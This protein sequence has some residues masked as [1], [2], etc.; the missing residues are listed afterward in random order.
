[1]AL[2]T[3]LGRHLS[4]LPPRLLQNLS[5]KSACPLTLIKVGT[6]D[7]TFRQ[8]RCECHYTSKL[9]QLIPVPKLA[10]GGLKESHSM[11]DP[12]Y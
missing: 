2:P 5:P 8:R 3:T 12:A 11:L 7:S 6:D 1:M 4:Q 9:S 10:E